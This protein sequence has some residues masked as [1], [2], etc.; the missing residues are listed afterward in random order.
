MKKHLT[1]STLDFVEARISVE[2]LSLWTKVKIIDLLSQSTRV[3]KDDV[4]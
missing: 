1:I 3:W 4:S 2:I